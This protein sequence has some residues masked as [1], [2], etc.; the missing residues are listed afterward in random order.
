[1]NAPA[2]PNIS[3]E[4]EKINIGTLNG[5]KARVSFD[6]ED[7]SPLGGIPLLVKL[8]GVDKFVKLF[9]KQIK[10]KRN[11]AM[12]KHT[13]KEM[14]TVMI[15][16]AVCGY[17]DR[18]DVTKL[19]H[20]PALR[21]ICHVKEGDELPSQPTLSRLEN[22]MSTRDLYNLGVFFVQSFID[23]YDT[24]PRSIILDMDDTNANAYG[25][26]QQSLFNTYYGDSCFMPLLLFEGISGKLILPMLRPGRCT[27]NINSFG[28]TRRVIEY[29]HAAWPQTIINFR[30]DCHFCNLLFMDWAHGKDYIRFTTGLSTN[31][32]LTSYVQ[33]LID[34]MKKKHDANPEITDVIYYKFNYKAKS[35][36][37]NQDVIAKIEINPAG[38]NVRYVVTNK[39]VYDNYT[40]LMVYSHYRGRGVCEL[41]IRNI[42]D[43]HA[44]K[45]S[46]SSFRANTFRLYIYAAAYVLLHRL[47]NAVA[48]YKP[49]TGDRRG[50]KRGMTFNTFIQ[51]I[52]RSSVV[53]RLDKKGYI[54]FHYNK[55]EFSRG[56][57]E[58]YYR[59]WQSRIA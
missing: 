2:L 48:P 3:T 18:N 16:L 12:C 21:N 39:T 15:V 9:C 52:M 44:D 36:K 29:I 13:L 34:M 50:V 47:K 37:Y 46:C 38:V 17:E 23:S 35:W 22:S 30:G 24:P 14:I 25:E 8:G 53:V 32:A 51:T 43:L 5:R 6:R 58:T 27:K 54:D 49:K 31:A 10:D 56:R 55:Y 11:P 40:S 42:K 7:L 57:M 26:Q 41:D 4:N 1:M 45:L 59:T 19:K 33:K 28:V 20:D